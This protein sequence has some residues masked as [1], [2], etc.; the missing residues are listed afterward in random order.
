MSERLWLRR[1]AAPWDRFLRLLVGAA[2]L[3]AGP[4]LLRSPYLLLADGLVAG[5]QMQAA[6]TG[7]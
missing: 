3:V 6:L 1:N 7:Y 2:L 5:L 4:Q